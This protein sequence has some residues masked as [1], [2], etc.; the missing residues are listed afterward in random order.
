MRVRLA[1]AHRLLSVNV[2]FVILAALAGCECA[3]AASVYLDPL[4][5]F[6]KA[7]AVTYGSGISKGVAVP[8]LADI[9]E[10]VGIGLAAIPAS[11]PAVVIQDG[12]AWTS[13]ERTRSRVTEP[14][15]YLAERGYT[16]IVADYRQGAPGL[17]FGLA[18]PG[19]Q[20]P[21]TVGQTK[22]G[23]APYAGITTSGHLYDIYPGVNP[24]RAG[25]EDFA[26]AIDW[27]RTNAGF[28]GID[29]GRIAIAGG[30]AGG[31]DALL[32]QYNQN[33][34]DP[35]YSAQAV[36]ALVA[37]MMNNVGRI[38]PG[39]PPVFL[40]NN[41]ADAVVP[42]SPAM[43]ARFGEVGIYREQWFQPADATYHGVDWNLD[44][45]GATLLE[46][47]RDFLYAQVAVPEPGSFLLVVVAVVIAGLG[48]SRRAG[49]E[50]F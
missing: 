45:G 29:P 5:G 38:Q 42:W 16:V 9:Y 10:P 28:L 15:I 20:A 13:A 17:P 19:P 47:T 14:A 39:G 26:V 1:C 31:I 36:V 8:L 25:I 34:V 7:S 12:G 41:T 35:R 23:T 46:R 24:I 30:S 18:E 27:A 33:P 43:S 37:T 50:Q 4:F 40:L 2:L 49:R 21:V 3:D 32:L 44:L 11:R 22:F 6:K 48:R